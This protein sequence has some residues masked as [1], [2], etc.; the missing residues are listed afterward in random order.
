MAQNNDHITSR[1]SE[2]IPGAKAEVESDLLSLIQAARGTTY[3]STYLRLRIN[4]GKLKAVKLGSN[5]FTTRQWVNE[6]INQYSVKSTVTAS[7]NNLLTPTKAVTAARVNSVKQTEALLLN[8]SLWEAGADLAQRF[9]DTLINK[10]YGA[11][12]GLSVGVNFWQRTINPKIAE[13]LRPLLNIDIRT[14]VTHAL[15]PMNIGTVR[16]FTGYNWF[17]TNFHNSSSV[18][19]VRR[20]SVVTATAVA[21]LVLVFSQAAWARHS[22][23]RAVQDY[24]DA[25]NQTVAVVKQASGYYA[26]TT[27]ELASR[28]SRLLASSLSNQLQKFSTPVA[29]AAYEIIY[30][31]N[32]LA[33]N[34]G[35]S[36]NKSTVPWNNLALA[37]ERQVGSELYNATLVYQP[38]LQFWSRQLAYAY[39]NGARA[40]VANSRAISLLIIQPAMDIKVGAGVLASYGQ[41]SLER[42]ADIWLAPVA[43]SLI[44]LTPQANI[45]P[46][47]WQVVTDR[48]R[49]VALAYKNVMA[50][51]GNLAVIGNQ[52]VELADS[53]SAPLSFGSRVILVE[54]ES[55][56]NG[57]NQ[58]I[59]TQE[60]RLGTFLASSISPYNLFLTPASRSLATSMGKVSQ[61]AIGIWQDTVL[62][63]T[64][65]VELAEVNTVN[66]HKAL[67]KSRSE[68]IPPIAE[69]VYTG[70]RVLGVTTKLGFPNSKT[71]L[72]KV[73]DLITQRSFTGV[74][75]DNLVSAVN[76][77]AK[78]KSTVIL[79]PAQ[80]VGEESKPAAKLAK[81]QTVTNAV[82]ATLIADVANIKDSL[83]IGAAP[84]TLTYSSATGLLDTPNLQ[85]RNNAIVAG[86]LIVR[87]QF[88]LEGQLALTNIAKLQVSGPADFQNLT[89]GVITA[90]TLNT[91]SLALSGTLIASGIGVSGS[92]GARDV[93]STYL[94]VEKDVT[95]GTTN[96]NKLTINSQAT[97][98]GPVTIA[99]P[100]TLNST[101]TL[102]GTVTPNP[103]ATSTATT[104][105]ATDT[106]SGASLVVANTTGID[107]GNLI[108]VGPAASNIWTRITA[109]AAGAPGTLTIVPSISRSAT[110][111]VAE[112]TTPSL[113]SSANI[114]NRFDKGYFLN[115]IVVGSGTTYI[116]DG[117]ISTAEG[118]LTLSAATG[119]KVNIAST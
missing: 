31:L 4:Q 8:R 69:V 33:D 94:S 60:Y 68:L 17:K 29:A 3:S 91:R 23:A 44:K 70:G 105:D 15:V 35:E 32:N 50:P 28:S 16:D 108:Q 66:V 21:I 41:G 27:T 43:R 110:Q 36:I 51:F 118:D 97:F 52:Y 12:A 45:W 2:P 85:V 99:S 78:S 37:V 65:P 6:Y 116:T 111:A 72:L 98:Q 38:S 89:A 93:T 64:G 7:A 102:T 114:Q 81:T 106:G 61:N 54:A 76:S 95:L 96:T 117:L 25:V 84:Q 103:T 80:G 26:A 86:N 83:I 112:Y 1:I 82:Y 77:K 22:L 5:W 53:F 18:L 88:N 73:R 101:T 58:K 75:D 11:G 14:A 87:G 19:L 56:L 39:E 90:S 59:L 107:A 55:L 109:V 46:A 113:G 40:F 47:L 49:A 79:N 48:P 20:W 62:T 34:I 63:Y 104:V 10:S 42:G 24:A 30:G 100:L 119:A 57:Y 13:I 115:G 9:F 71:V 74:Q 92:V 67:V